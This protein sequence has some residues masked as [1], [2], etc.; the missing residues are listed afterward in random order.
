[1]KRLAAAAVLSLCVIAA[2]AQTT[3]QQILT[4]SPWTIGIMVA[5]WIMK[6]ERKIFYVEVTAQGATLEEARKQ[7]MRMA[8]ERAVGSVAS[9]ATEAK[10]SRLVRDEII[11]YSSGY[12]DD[13]RVINQQL[14]NGQTQVQMKIWVSHSK[15]ANRLLGESKTTGQIEGGRISAQIETFQ[16]ERKSGDQLLLQVL[17]DYPSKS[18]HVVMDKT[19][20]WVHTD[21]ETYITIPFRLYWDKNYIES[22][23]E[24]MRLIQQ[25][26]DCDSWI[27]PC[28][29][30]RVVKV[31]ND[32]YGFDDEQ[33][34]NL[35]W[36]EIQ[37]SRPQI[38]LKLYDRSN[39][40]QWQNCFTLPEL[41]SWDSA[42]NAWVYF[43]GS[44]VSIDPYRKQLAN[45][46]LPTKS[47]PMQNL[48]RADIEIV[49]MSNC[50]KPRR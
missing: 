18:F 33:A 15:L 8:V 10:N 23:S 25:R 30:T 2:Q 3:V 13:Y 31:A 19:Q 48:D 40:L 39:Q 42:W 1:M 28:T 37:L 41:D 50:P 7:A 46:T 14:V 9:T 45:V 27:L 38:L 26:K 17:R 34:V 43:N 22:F 49:R 6:E 20:I 35:M 44:T 4:P 24:T 5:Q 16:H 47:L 11:V 36:Q 29:A 12:V 21:R 32:R